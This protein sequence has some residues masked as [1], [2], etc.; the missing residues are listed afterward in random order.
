VIAVFTV[1]FEGPFWVGVL[2]SEEG[3]RLVVARHVFG[4][5]PSNVELL[6][7]MLRRFS[8]MPRSEHRALELEDD[9]GQAERAGR[10]GNPK[11]AQRDAMRD[12]ARPPSTK[13]RAALSAARGEAKAERA[14]TSR[15]ARLEEAS[16]RFE[17]RAEK[18]KRKR[19]GH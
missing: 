3:G 16:R 5:E 11:R 9:R 18:R 10:R 2:E 14:I 7:F 8:S 19:S 12:I 15:A 13:A 1:Y 17:L 6:D 4:S